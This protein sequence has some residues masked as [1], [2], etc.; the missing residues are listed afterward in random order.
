MYEARADTFRFYGFGLFRVFFVF[1][2]SS[3]FCFRVLFEFFW[4]T[5]WAP[6]L[7]Y[8]VCVSR[9]CTTCCRCV[10]PANPTSPSLRA[11]APTPFRSMIFLG[12]HRYGG[13]K[14]EVERRGASSAEQQD[15]HVTYFVSSPSFCEKGASC[16]DEDFSISLVAFCRWQRKHTVV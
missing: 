15:G 14:T 16:A 1:V 5:K 9:L 12:N 7:R 8:R 6:A 3:P 10:A 13:A 4:A 11:P 2:L